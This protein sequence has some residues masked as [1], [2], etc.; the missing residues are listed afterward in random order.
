MKERQYR[1][2]QGRSP[3]QESESLRIITI[4]ISVLTFIIAFLIFTQ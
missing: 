1:S 2:N 3:Q 4:S